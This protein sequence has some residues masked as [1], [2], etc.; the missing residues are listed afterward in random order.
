MTLVH[1][2]RG[3]G[4]APV[5]LLNGGMMTSAS[6]EP[7]TQRLLE[8]GCYRVVRCDFR[9]QLGSPGPPPADL[10]GHMEDVAHLLDALSLDEVHVVGTSFGGEVG[11]LLAATHPERVSSLV[12][13]T[14]TDHLTVEMKA[15]VAESR[16][17]VGGV[18]AGGS[19]REFQARV[20]EEVY[21]PAFRERSASLLA[22]I[23]ERSEA[24][25]A[26]WFEHLDG[27]LSAYG[28]TDLR[29]VL[30]DV[31]CPVLVV[32]GGQDQ[33]MPPERS[34]ALA[35]ALDGAPEVV[36]AT[37]PASGHALVIE[38]PGWL[39]DVCLSFLDRQTLQGG[40]S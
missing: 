17:Q 3:D 34:R 10:A 30:S 14:V 31:A 33:V 5:L 18:L 4:D 2:V 37:H 7:L 27:I 12:A 38:Q 39:A 21:S 9:G 26:V 40:A 6:W 28:A 22:A 25:P 1:E 8:A 35:V 29:P 24:L 20:A 23:A 19:R 16:A 15:S 13:V 11:L 36:I 32:I